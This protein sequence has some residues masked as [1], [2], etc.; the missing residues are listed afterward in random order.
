MATERNTSQASHQQYAHAN[1]P[2][3]TFPSSTMF[4]QIIFKPLTMAKSSPLRAD[5]T[6]ECRW[7]ARLHLQC[8]GGHACSPQHTLLPADTLLTT[9]KSRENKLCAHSPFPGRAR[10]A[11]DP[12]ASPSATSLLCRQAKGGRAGP[13]QHRARQT[14][15][16]CLED[17]SCLPGIWEPR[18]LCKHLRSP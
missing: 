4:Q 5:T 11:G 1:L 2:M 15:T 18:M 17:I 6:E 14:S 8:L 12:S 3:K 13:S 9:P 7:E 16:L 10:C